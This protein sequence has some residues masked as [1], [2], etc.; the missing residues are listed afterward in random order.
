MVIESICPK[1]GE[2]NNVE[3]N[4]E[5]ILIVQCKNNHFYDHIVVPYSRTAEINDDRRKKLEEMIIE[6]KFCRMSDKSTICLLI[7]EN[8]YEVEG[9]STVKNKDDFHIVIGKDKAYEHALKN[10][11]VALGAYLV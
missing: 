3:H 10:A 7:F 6:K 11:M 4:G 2:I 1:C 5:Q 9:R 8:G